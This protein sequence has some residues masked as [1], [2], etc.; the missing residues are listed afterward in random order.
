T[1][2]LIEA[3]SYAE[4]A[5]APP[6]ADALHMAFSNLFVQTEVVASLQAIVCTRRPRSREEAV[7]FMLHLMAVHGAESTAPSYET[8]RAAFIGRGRT[9]ASPRALAD[10]GELSGAQGSV[11]DPIVAIRTQVSLEPGQ[12]AIIDIVSGVAATRAAALELAGKYR[13]RRLADR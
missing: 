8:G 7:P 2:R 11:L 3:T 1:R 10:R 13:D 6:A 12:T 4:V 5:L 9:V